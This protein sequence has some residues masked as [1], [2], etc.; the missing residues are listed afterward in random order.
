VGDLL[1][2]VQMTATLGEQG[3]VIEVVRLEDCD[4]P[5]SG[6]YCTTEQ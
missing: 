6:G 3:L 2:E 1:N 5:D 4:S